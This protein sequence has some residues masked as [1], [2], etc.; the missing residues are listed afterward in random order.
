MNAA[1]SRTGRRG[2]RRCALALAAALALPGGGR[3]LPVEGLY[4]HRVEVADES[5]AERGRAFREALAAV[6][7]K[8]TG[9]RRW[10]ERPAVERALE[11]AESLVE[12]VGYEVDPGP[13][14]R[15]RI[16][17][18]FAPSLVDR[19]LFD[20]GIPVW[21]GN[22]PS[23]LVWLVLQDETGARTLPAPDTH[24]ELFDV[25]RRFAED[26]GLPVIFPLLDFE[27]RRG[28]AE[29]RLWALDR[30]AIVRASARY[31]ADSVLAGRVHF[32]A[33]GDLVGL[34]R[35]LFRDRNELFD[36][37][38]TEPRAYLR[39]PLDRVTGWL[40]EHFALAPGAAA[41]G[42]VRMR[43]DG[44]G[45]LRDYS[46]LLAYLD[47]L[48]LVES[49][50]PALLDGARIELEIA[51]RDEPARLFELIELDRELVPVR[52]ARGRPDPVAHYRWNR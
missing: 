41:R 17:V 32:T 19:L 4:S 42:G 34:W 43:V 20:A 12:A 40:A 44:V 14:E 49:V 3:A 7:L 1:R 51:L 26:R 46:A 23:V 33:G 11:T 18:F 29:D 47:G 37:F 50:A 24:P 15:R 13:P 21:D 45:D 16:D 22:R 48:T 2:A 25:M 31:G 30:D 5:V 10:L 39:A 28:L 52:G 6:V 35:F 9:D 27:D 8:V 36:G 38:D